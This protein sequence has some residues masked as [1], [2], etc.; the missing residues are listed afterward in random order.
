MWTERL[1]AFQHKCIEILYLINHVAPLLSHTESMPFYVGSY[2]HFIARTYRL[3]YLGVFMPKPLTVSQCQRLWQGH[4]FLW[5]KAVDE[6]LL[7]MI[8]TDKNM[9][10]IHVLEKN[11]VVYWGCRSA[12]LNGINDVGMHN[13]D[14]ADN[15]KLKPKLPAAEYSDFFFLMLWTT[16]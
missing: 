7:C 3:I 11:T 13:I 16:K 8:I 5:A 4:Q 9:T 1:V 2:S 10:I 6:V 12:L 14:R 15:G